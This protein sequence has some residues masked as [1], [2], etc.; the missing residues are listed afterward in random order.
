LGWKSKERID[1]AVHEQLHGFDAGTPD[2]V[3]V[4]VRVKPD[5]RRHEGQVQ[6]SG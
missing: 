2:P 1:L 5:L 6:V 4:L 3:D